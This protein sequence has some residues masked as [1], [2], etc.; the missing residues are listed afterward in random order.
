MR[1]ILLT[2][3]CLLAA[4]CTHSGA[5]LSPSTNVIPPLANSILGS[6]TLEVWVV[7][8]DGRP[9][10][11][12]DVSPVSLSINGRPVETDAAGR[13][14]VPTD[15]GLQQ[16]QWVNVE[17]AGYEPVQ[18]DATNA[19]PLRITLHPAART[20]AHDTLAPFQRLF[21]GMTMNAVRTRV[22]MPDKQTGSGLAIDIYH[23]ADGSEVWLGFAGRK[24]LLY[25]RHGHDGPDLLPP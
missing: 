24:G 23:L 16:L 12:A 18:V 15:V 6:P 25:V 19:R 20:P 5:S 14:R 11:D 13:A 9:L 17:K 2:T 1:A 22:G 8:T 21:R 3:L 7:D 4:G 10:P